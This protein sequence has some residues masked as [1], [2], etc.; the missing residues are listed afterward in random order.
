MYMKGYKK[1]NELAY[2]TK[3]GR[4]FTVPCMD[5]LEIYEYNDHGMSEN[6]TMPHEEKIQAVENVEIKP[7]SQ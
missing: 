4:W 1:P 3:D 5:F 7:A 6:S 2:R